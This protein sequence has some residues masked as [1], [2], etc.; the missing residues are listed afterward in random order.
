MALPAMR[1]YTEISVPVLLRGEKKRA[2]FQYHQHHHT[3]EP[4]PGSE[5]HQEQKVH[6]L[7][8][9]NI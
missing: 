8:H 6:V 2:V 4:P 5:V 9:Q 7:F 1:A 3:L